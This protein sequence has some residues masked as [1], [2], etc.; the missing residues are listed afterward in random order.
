MK[1][2]LKIL[3]VIFAIF[4]SVFICQIICYNNYNVFNSENVKFNNH[5]GF[6]ENQVYI[7]FKDNVSF[8]TIK[9]LVIKLNGKIDAEGESIINSYAITLNRV[10]ADVNEIDKFCN[11]LIK[12]YNIIED[13]YPNYIYY[14]D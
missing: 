10:F 7:Y 9:R 13:C 8:S 6:V 3:L 4:F 5:K 14:L 11:K 1:K 12:K 2:T